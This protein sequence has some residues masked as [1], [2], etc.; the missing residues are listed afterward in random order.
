GYSRSVEPPWGMDHGDEGTLNCVEVERVD[1]SVDRYSFA[2]AVSVADNEIV[3]IVTGCGAG[4]GSPRARSAEAIA[5]DM[6]NGQ[7]SRDEAR[8]IYGANTS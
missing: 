6:K 5:G 2:S 4:W 3:R 1:G 8:D 7:L